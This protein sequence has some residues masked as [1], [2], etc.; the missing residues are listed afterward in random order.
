MELVNLKT[1]TDS[2]Q[3]ESGETRTRDE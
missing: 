2:Y 3:D 1:G